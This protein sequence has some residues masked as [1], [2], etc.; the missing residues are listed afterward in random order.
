MAALC[1]GIA[2]VAGVVV[3]V[4]A[5]A[6]D[7]GPRERVGLVTSL[8][9]YWNDGAAFE[10]LASP[11]AAP[12]WVRTALE[13]R[14]DLVPVDG[15]AAA[16]DTAAAIAPS[17][18]L[19][20][21]DFLILAQ[22]RALRPAEYVALDNWVRGGGRVMIFADPLL[23]EHSEFSLGDPRR[24]QGAALLSPI[25]AHWGLTQSYDPAQA[26][27]IRLVDSGDGQIPVEAAGQFAVAISK[28]AD[29]R[30]MGRGVLADCT[31]GSGRALILGDAAVLD[32]ETEAP[33]S[34]NALD[35]LIESA[36]RSRDASN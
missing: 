32:G 16:D 22:P 8:P 3:G 14:Y 5:M 6:P 21:L 18:E 4:V 10:T 2:A 28:N 7:P 19:A 27:G 23:T 24:P 9:I 1:A 26:P 34:R 33:A 30:I 31:V 12:H 17:A 35:T 25:L 11:D 15:L 29:C 20:G 36:F 13:E